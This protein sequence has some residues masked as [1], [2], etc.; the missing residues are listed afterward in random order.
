MATVYN[1]STGDIKYINQF[2]DSIAI[3]ALGDSII[4]V[5]DSSFTSKLST[6]PSQTNTDFAIYTEVPKW[7]FVNAN[8]D[9]KY[10][11]SAASDA[12]GRITGTLIKDAHDPSA[13]NYAPIT[14]PLMDT[15]SIKYAMKDLVRTTRFSHFLQCSK[16]FKNSFK[17][18]NPVSIP[19]VDASN[20][21]VLDASGSQMNRVAQLYAVYLNKSTGEALPYSFYTASG[22]SNAMTFYYADNPGFLGGALSVLADNKSVVTS[23]DGSAAPLAVVVPPYPGGS[24]SSVS[25][26][27]LSDVNTLSGIS[28]STTYELPPIAMTASATAVSLGNPIIDGVYTV[29][30]SSESIGFEGWRAASKTASGSW[31]E[32]S[33]NAGSLYAAPANATYDIVI[34]TVSG[35]G[36]VTY[37]GEWVKITLPFSTTIRSYKIRPISVRGSYIA[38]SKWTLLGNVVAGTSGTWLQLDSR[39]AQTWTAPDEVTFNV[40][41]QPDTLFQEVILVIENMYGCNYGGLASLTLFDALGNAVPSIKLTGDITPAP[42][43]TGNYIAS[44]SNSQNTVLMAAWSIFGNSSPTSSGYWITGRDRYI[45]PGYSAYAGNSLTRDISGGVTVSGEYIQM[46]LPNPMTITSYSIRCDGVFSTLRD[47]SLWGSYNSVDWYLLDTQTNV[48]AYSSVSRTFTYNINS[49]Y[50]TNNG[51]PFNYVRLVVSRL[52]NTRVCKLDEL[53]VYGVNPQFPAFRFPPVNNFR[54]ASGTVAVNSMTSG[55]YTFSSSFSPSGQNVQDVFN[56]STNSW[57]CSGGLYCSAPYRGTLLNIDASTGIA[58]SGEWIQLQCPSGIKVASYSFN[59]LGPRSFTLMGSNNG[60]SWNLIHASSG[61]SELSYPV[62]TYPSGNLM[63]FN[64]PTPSGGYQTYSYYRLVIQD[65][66]GGQSAAKITELTFRDAS[67]SA[68]PPTALISDT[69]GNGYISSA[70][71]T[72]SGG[73]FAYFAFDKSGSTSWQSASLYS[74]G[75]FGNYVGSTSTTTVSGVTY[76]GEWVQ[77]SLP[78]STILTTYAINCVMFSA[79]DPGYGISSFALLGSSNGTTWQLVDSSNNINWSSTRISNG[80]PRAVVFNPSVTAAYRHYRLVITGVYAPQVQVASCPATIRNVLMF[81]RVADRTV[82]A[83]TFLWSPPS[84]YSATNPD[85]ASTMQHIS[86]DNNRAMLLYWDVNPLTTARYTGDELYAAWSS[87]ILCPASASGI[88]PLR[89]LDP[90]S[91]NYSTSLKTQTNQFVIPRILPARTPVQVRIGMQTQIDPSGTPRLNLPLSS[92]TVLQKI[93]PLDPSAATRVIP[94]AYE[95]ANRTTFTNSSTS[96]TMMGGRVMQMLSHYL[97]SSTSDAT[98]ATFT[99]LTNEA[100]R[101]TDAFVDS[102]STRLASNDASGTAR[103]NDFLNQILMR[104]GRTCFDEYATLVNSSSATGFVKDVIRN[105][106]DVF[107]NFAISLDTRVSNRSTTTSDTI[108]FSQIPVIIRLTPSIFSDEIAPF[109]EFDANYVTTSSTN[110]SLITAWPNLA[111]PSKF[112]TFGAGLTQA[113]ASGLAGSGPLLSQ[114]A[115]ASGITVPAVTLNRDASAYFSI[116]TINFNGCLANS[117]LTVVFVAA[118][119]SAADQYVNSNNEGL[120]FFRADNGAVL[121]GLSRGN[122]SVYN[123]YTNASPAY[124]SGAMSTPSAL[125]NVGQRQVFAVTY[126]PVVGPSG[127]TTT[128]RTYVNNVLL[129]TVSGQSAIQ[130]RITTSNAIGAMYPGSAGWPTF[131]GFIHQAQFYPTALSDSNLSSLYTYLKNRWAL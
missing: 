27:S 125:A 47:F 117:G 7:M 46:F 95:V 128:V 70:S 69:P 122:D 106:D 45:Q 71:T 116:P 79:S 18:G 51:L 126:T 57:S 33:Q 44:A 68:F 43:G 87:V 130:D 82:P 54:A 78:V 129:T 102:V 59:G 77:M 111:F 88:I 60:S 21:P 104:Y 66:N 48:G 8:S 25:A 113:Y 62:G 121:R 80:F 28:T 91:A 76:S 119:T 108:R 65:A 92:Y 34:T 17:V 16:F 13:I 72:A 29:T 74:A 14:V 103:R 89:D 96:N 64:I 6:L 40:S 2:N 35:P 52:N 41:L 90:S 32:S 55:L 120:Y 26:S 86:T 50:N 94:F 105:L 15:T 124:N 97:F 107:I 31:W 3:D 109:M 75:G 85:F 73:N 1:I 93:N 118:Y 123:I 37:S 63:T 22:T 81:G 98:M 101:I 24:V 5:D 99:N 53:R 100:N 83:T 10:T 30:T 36:N 4:L 38:P 112:T 19:V 58:Y 110:A 114:I 49:G 42:D 61:L 127:T 20:N 23:L 39:S 9:W 56:N 67:N 12:S 131:Q 115:T 11:V 84:T